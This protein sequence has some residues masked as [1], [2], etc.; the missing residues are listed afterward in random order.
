MVL[1]VID[2]QNMITNDSLYKFDL[3]VSNIKKLISYAREKNIEV[4]YVRHDDGVSEL[5]TKGNYEFEIFHEFKPLKNERIFDKIVNSAFKDTGFEH[6]FNIIVPAFCN[7][8]IA[9]EFM[10]EEQSYLYYNDF[11]WNNRYAK[12]ISLEETLK[13]F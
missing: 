8:T 2:T 1:L 10:D 6:G 3:F 4:I 11:I 13:L 5:L 12:C 9:N 7:S